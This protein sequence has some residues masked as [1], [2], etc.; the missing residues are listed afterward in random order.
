MNSDRLSSKEYWAGKYEVPTASQAPFTTEARLKKWVPGWL[1]QGRKM[2]LRR[3]ASRQL[4]EVLLRPH[5]EGR[6]GLRGIE[7]GSAPGWQSLGLWKR[8]G[9]VPYGLEYTETGVQLQRALYRAQGLAEDLVLQGDFFDDALRARWHEAFDLVASYG[10]I[11]HF[12]NPEDVLVKHLDLLR[13]G[14]LLVVTVPNLN[15]RAWYGRL[16]KRYNPAVYAICNIQTC[17][18]ETLAALAAKTDCELLY[19]DTIGGPEVNF[20]ADDRW[21]GRFLAGLLRWID[22]AIN[23][24]NHVILGTRMRPFPR[25]ASTIALVAVKKPA[26]RAD[27]QPGPE[28]TAE[29]HGAVR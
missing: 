21:C 13:P 27:V 19:C 20:V 12:S 17:T 29:S 18:R 8:F 14:G 6:N 1:R 26:A 25:T 22:P 15:D 7:I 24:L 2:L 5:V 4:L 23:V 10:F 16:V 28:L 11:E 3:H 9:I